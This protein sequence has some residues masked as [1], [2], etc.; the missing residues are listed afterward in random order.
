MGWIS[1]T[2]RLPKPLIRVWVLTD[3]GKQ[4][5]AYIRKSGEWFLFCRKISADN[6]VITKWRE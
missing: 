2:D 4:T 6:P 5:T 3:S 1:V